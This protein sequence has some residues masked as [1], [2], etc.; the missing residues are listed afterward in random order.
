MSNAAISV[1]NVY[2]GRTSS[3]DF[4][5]QGGCLIFRPVMPGINVEFLP[6]RQNGF[7]RHAGPGGCRSPRGAIFR[8][9]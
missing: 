4:A 2:R 1:G 6:I 8:Q 5:G 3:A 9:D 7:R